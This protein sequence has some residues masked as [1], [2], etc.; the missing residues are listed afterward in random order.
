VPHLDPAVERVL[1]ALVQGLRALNVRFCVIGALV[2]GLLLSERPEQATLDADAVVFVP[3]LPTFERV[4]TG[5]AGFKPTKYPYRL[6]HESGGRADILPYSDEIAP[7]GVLRLEPDY[8]F[9]MTGF[10]RVADAVVE[11]TLESGEHV[12][13]VLVSVY[14]LLKLVAFTDRKLEK[15]IGGVLHCLRNYAEDDDRRFG[16]EHDGKPVPYEYGSA[17]LLARDALPFVDHKLRQLIAPLLDSLI[18]A[19]LDVDDHNSHRTKENREYL[20]WFRAGLGL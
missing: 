8:V 14:V 12:P 4:K 20:R 1:V 18:T 11:V 2:P 17:Y 5:L 6:R 9:N 7:D 3:D 16:L 15:D 13:V 10:N 19:D